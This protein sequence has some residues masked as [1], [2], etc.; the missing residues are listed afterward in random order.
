MYSV[1]I[2]CTVYYEQL[3][4]D[5][6]FS[7]I[8]FQKQIASKTTTK[9]NTVVVNT[10]KPNAADSPTTLPTCKNEKFPF[11]INAKNI[12]CTINSHLHASQ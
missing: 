10:K 2:L 12:I 7:L 9:S 6:P 3:Q 8:F 11:I 1:I 5:V 4:A